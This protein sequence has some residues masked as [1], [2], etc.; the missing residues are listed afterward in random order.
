MNF[1]SPHQAQTTGEIEKLKTRLCPRGDLQERGQWDTWCPIAGDTTGAAPSYQQGEWFDTVGAECR[2]VRDNVGLLD[3]GGFTKYNVQGDGTTQWLD[4]LIAGKMPRQGRLSLSYF[5]AE[6]GGVWSEM[7]I[8]RL[9]DEHYLLITASGA[10]WHDFQWL[11][12]HLPEDSSITI[13]DI[14][15]LIHRVRGRLRDIE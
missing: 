15:Y 8:T 2:N 4:S 11:E 9:A 10:K 7:T 5:C 14:L 1:L 13:N 6:D 3:L 12:E